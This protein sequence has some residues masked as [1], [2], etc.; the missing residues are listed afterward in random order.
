MMSLMASLMIINDITH[1]QSHDD[2][3]R[4]HDVCHLRHVTYVS[5]VM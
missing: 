5:Y 3:N 2:V 1:D 4:S